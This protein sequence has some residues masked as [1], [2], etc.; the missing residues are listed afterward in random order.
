MT[1][2]PWPKV[3]PVMATDRSF[4]AGRVVVGSVAIVI[5]GAGALEN[6]YNGARMGETGQGHAGVADAVGEMFGLDGEGLDE[7]DL[8]QEDVAAAVVELGDLGLIEIHV[9]A[10]NGFAIYAFVV[11]GDFVFRDVVVND[12]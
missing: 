8:G 12:H 3:T 4:G 6:A 7:F 11:D 1:V 10:E 9:L 5:P 2:T